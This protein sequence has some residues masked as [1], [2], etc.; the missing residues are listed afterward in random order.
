MSSEKWSEHPSAQG[1]CIGGKD[2]EFDEI[3]LT[4]SDVTEQKMKTRDGDSEKKLCLHFE[5]DTRL[6]PLNKTR[7]NYMAKHCGDPIEEWIGEKV[8]LYGV[9]TPMG[10]GVRIKLGWAKKSKKRDDDDRDD[11]REERRGK[12]SP[13][14]DDDRPSPKAAKRRREEDDYEDDREDD[15]EERE[16]DRPTVKRS[17]KMRRAA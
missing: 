2:V 9:D 5:E 17:V 3:E 14:D 8:T 4:I 10:T 1:N 16:R 11:D 13:T 7:G 12:R 15:R 6:L